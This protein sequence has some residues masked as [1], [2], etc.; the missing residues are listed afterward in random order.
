MLFRSEKIDMAADG[1]SPEDPR[2]ILMSKSVNV[3]KTAPAAI[4]GVLAN[5]GWISGCLPTGRIGAGGSGT[6]G[7]WAIGV[8]GYNI[9]CCT[10]GQMTVAR[11]SSYFGDACDDTLQTA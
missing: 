7:I 6:I 9:I 1:L 11:E 4:Q 10:S 3:S 8:S 2:R 5:R